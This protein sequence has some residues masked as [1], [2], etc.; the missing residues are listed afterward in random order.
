[1]F[2]QLDKAR[3][4]PDNL[5][6]LQ[7]LP[8]NCIRLRSL[9]TENVYEEVPQHLNARALRQKWSFPS[10][11]RGHVALKR[12]STARRRAG[13]SP[14]VGELRIGGVDLS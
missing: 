4:C 6:P 9:K 10:D 11:K 14:G 5:L 8:G 2:L 1:M 13:N 7:N 3:D 12:F